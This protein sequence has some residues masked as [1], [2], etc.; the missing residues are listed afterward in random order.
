MAL[1]NQGYEPISLGGRGHVPS[2]EV[3]IYDTSS[4]HKIASWHDHGDSI[5]YRNVTN[6]GFSID[7]SKLMTVSQDGVV[8][9]RNI[10]EALTQ[11]L[12]SLSKAS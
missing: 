8:V 5:A 1:S 11:V 10:Q 12:R 4:K 6:A 7:D 3:F 9:V 2:D